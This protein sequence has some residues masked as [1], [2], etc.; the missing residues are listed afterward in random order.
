MFI[1]NHL[2]ILQFVEVKSNSE[3]VRVNDKTLRVFKLNTSFFL[4]QLRKTS[5]TLTSY[6]LLLSSYLK[7]KFKFRLEGLWSI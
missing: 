4:T 5:L 7:C 1:P 2:Y 3:K 6:L